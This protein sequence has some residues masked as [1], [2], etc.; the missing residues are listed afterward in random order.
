MKEELIALI[1]EYKQSVS[2]TNVVSIEKEKEYLEFLLFGLFGETGSILEATKK[3]MREKKEYSNIEYKN[4]IIE[5]FGDTLWYFTAI[6]E[7]V[8]I[9][10]IKLLDMKVP[11]NKSYNQNL[12]SLGGIAGKLLSISGAEKNDKSLL[13]EFGKY[14]LFSLQKSSM[15][16]NLKKVIEYNM[17]KIKDRFIE[18]SDDELCAFNADYPIDE[19]IPEKF[20]IMII[21]RSSKE[22]YL[23]WNGVFIGN[24]LKDNV[25]EEDGY[26]FHDVFHIAYAAI[27]HWSPVFRSLIKHKRKSR[28][29]IDNTE[30]SGRAI[31]IEEGLTVWIFSIA[32]K[33]N[34]FKNHDKIPWSIL[35]TVQQFIRGYEV[36][37]C[38]L[39]LWEKAI[40]EGYKVYREVSK[41]KKGKIIADLQSRTIKYENL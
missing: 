39:K 5:E 21:E 15:E 17:Q 20:T 26:R 36:E 16:D 40:L 11:K 25:Y 24:P 3:K 32:K 35:K 12:L 8:K 10:I 13:C 29:G 30:D 23:Q 19:Q 37:K 41:N 9:D 33:S 38:P 34:Y 27:L 22:T 31:V 18:P 7:F 6:C 2:K 14:F 1:E 4:T 28:I